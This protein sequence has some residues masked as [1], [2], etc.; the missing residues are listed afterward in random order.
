MLRSR[1]SVEEDDFTIIDVSSTG[2]VVVVLI[3]LCAIGV[4]IPL[5]RHEKAM[6][7]A[8]GE[9]QKLL[10]RPLGQA[11]VRKLQTGVVIYAD[12]VST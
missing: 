8:Y 12:H 3:V 9:K 11:T 10:P 6:E 5:D 1:T 4:L 2:I 7:K